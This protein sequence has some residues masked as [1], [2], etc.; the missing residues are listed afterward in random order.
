MNKNAYRTELDRV[1]FTPEGRKSLTDALMAEQLTAAPPARRRNWSRIG[2]AAGLA[3]VVLAGSAFAAAGPLWERYFGRL[4]ETQ[5]EVIDTLSQENLPAAESNGTIMTPLAAFGDQDFYY[6]MLEITPPEGTVLPVY[7]K[8]EGYYQF[9]NPDTGEDMTLTDEAGNDIRTQW[10]FEWMPRNSEESP[11][12]AVIRLWPRTGVDY[13]DGTDKILHLPGLWVQDPDKNYT[14]VLTGGWDFNIGA[15]SGNIENRTLDTAGM[16]MENEN[17]GT[18][19][20]ESMRLSPLGMRYRFS[21]AHG[22][23]D[24]R[25]VCPGIETVVV[26]EDG[27]RVQLANTMGRLHDEERWHETYGPFESPVDL[28]KAAYIL[29]GTVQIP[30]N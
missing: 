9:S 6:L 26:M 16:I 15:H 29:W 24:K 19:T 3:A 14:P 28:S 10:E 7:G 22:A 20:L 11:L 4:D 25:L 23:E 8:D 1:R 27:S 2:I 18:V 13:S 30:L 12:T 21:W 5:Q 17:F